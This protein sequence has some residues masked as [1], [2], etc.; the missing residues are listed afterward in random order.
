MNEVITGVLKQAIQGT[1]G[2]GGRADKLAS[3][4]SLA[5]IAG[6]YGLI[7]TNAGSEI[8][9]IYSMAGALIFRLMKVVESKGGEKSIIELR[10][11]VIELQSKINKMKEE[12]RIN[13]SSN[14]AN[15]SDT[16]DTGTDGPGL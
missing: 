11:L 5:F 13:V 9:A 12:K 10:E 2:E 7:E 3:R 8:W 4:E 1:L 6:V 15:I 16:Q 14:S